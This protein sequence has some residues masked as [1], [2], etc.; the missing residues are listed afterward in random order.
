MIHLAVW[1]LP[2]KAEL[3]LITKHR[4]T[5]LKSIITHYKLDLSPVVLVVPHSPSHTMVAGF[6]DFIKRLF[7]HRHLDYNLGKMSTCNSRNL[8]PGK[9]VPACLEPSR[10]NSFAVDAAINPNV[11][12]GANTAGPW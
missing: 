12:L 1:P 9:T 8:G 4:P 2:H 5:H 3:L 10:Q 6:D 7:V 11:C